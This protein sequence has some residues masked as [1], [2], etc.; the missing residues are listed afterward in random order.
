M[1]G[2]EIWIW[3]RLGKLVGGG[4]AYSTAGGG[5]WWWDKEGGGE[6]DRKGSYA[7]ISATGS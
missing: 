6:G 1:N 7:I 5:W 3:A 4:G 2:E